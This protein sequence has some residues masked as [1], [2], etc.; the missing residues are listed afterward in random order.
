MTIGTPPQQFSVQLDTGSADIWVP[1]VGSDICRQ[2]QG[3]CAEGSFDSTASSTFVDIGPNS[4]QIQ[5]QDNSAINGDYITDTVAIGKTKITNMTMGLATQA[6][7]D[8]GIMG[9]GYNAD[10]SIL[11]QDPTAA[12]PNIVTQMKNNGFIRTLAYS[13]WL[14]DPS[15][16]SHHWENAATNM[17]QTP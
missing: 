5:Y 11:S 16:L 6:T 2:G 13:L 17:L 7:R 8:L 3:T 12:Y 15:E 10:E 14:N 1:S 9:I 4:F